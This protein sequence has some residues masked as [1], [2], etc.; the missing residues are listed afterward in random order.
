MNEQGKYS[1]RHDKQR[2]ESYH[3]YGERVTPG[4]LDPTDMSA[5]VDAETVF[6][7]TKFE[8]HDAEKAKKRK[9]NKLNEARLQLLYYSSSFTV[10]HFFDWS[11]A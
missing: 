3:R 8:S 11:E 7:M 2:S 10:L 1:E 4:S 9:D 5:P 6:Q